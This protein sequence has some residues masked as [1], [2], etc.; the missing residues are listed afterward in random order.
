[1]DQFSPS[2]SGIKPLLNFNP[3][4]D[5]ISFYRSRT[6]LYTHV[7]LISILR[8]RP[9][10]VD[11]LSAEK[12][13]VLNGYKDPLSPA[14]KTFIFILYHAMARILIPLCSLTVSFLFIPNRSLTAHLRCGA[15][16]GVVRSPRG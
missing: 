2:F 13:Y 14:M 7:Q 16:R 11:E 10:E 4:Y 6:C 5:F 3:P 1:M 15:H 9:S 8:R 12:E